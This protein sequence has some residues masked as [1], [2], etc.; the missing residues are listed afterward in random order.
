MKNIT[1][2]KQENRK[3]RA[4]KKLV[5]SNGNKNA[6]ALKLGISYRHVNRLIQR[7]HEQG[8]EA[9]VHR[10]K[11]K[12]PR[13]AIPSD[14]KQAVR[15]LYTDKS[16]PFHKSNFKHFSELLKREFDINISH[17]SIHAI[18]SEEHILPP[19]A[20]R[21]KRKQVKKTLIAQK[22][23][24]PS[25]AQ[26]AEIQ[27]KI[28]SIENPHP[29][30]PRAKH[31]GQLVQ[32]DASQH[33]WFG[34]TYSFLHI[35]VDDATSSILGAYFDTQETLKG[36]YHVTKQ[37]LTTY[38][39]PY[40]FYT[41]RRTVFEYKRKQKASLSPVEIDYT[42]QFAYACKQLGIELKTTSVA[43]AKGRVERMFGSLQSRLLV[44]LELAG[45]TSIEQANAFLY[46]YIQQY[47]L[48]F[49]YDP[50]HI[51]SVFEKQPD[52]QSINCILAVL[53][54]RKIDNGHTIKFQNARYFPIDKK[55]KPVFLPYKTPCIVIRT[56]D[57]TLL[58]SIKDQI[59]GM[60][61]IP[62]REKVSPY[63]LAEKEIHIQPSH[64][65]KLPPML[66]AWRRDAFLKFAA[67]Q[68]HRK[69]PENYLL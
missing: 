17:S 5:E 49:S 38:G 25:L 45:V 15:D 52:P 13:H 37:I 39:I 48:Q 6:V 41:D 47:N 26:K 33:R 20:T 28:V 67:S 44:E 22:Y 66:Y 43:Q 8:K 63:F 50:Y 55:G 51:T 56:L 53:A 1:L 16:L 9:F 29:S 34:S 64:V 24:A 60:Q 21:S 18:M 11:G 30:R 7:Y 31:F 62:F 19:K 35:A 54:D 40:C 36:Y 3:Y 58:V 61:E 69:S 14:L 65:Q 32:M 57:D 23:S 59:F 4:I 68:P 46:S 2:N 10:N 42:T 12:T 27:K